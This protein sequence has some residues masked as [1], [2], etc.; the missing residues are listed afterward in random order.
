MAVLST[1]RDSPGFQLLWRYPA[2]WFDSVE[3]IGPEPVS[4][5]VEAGPEPGLGIVA[6]A[7]S[8]R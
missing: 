6:V 4:K 8:R 5:M 7:L 2:P 1:L 3:G